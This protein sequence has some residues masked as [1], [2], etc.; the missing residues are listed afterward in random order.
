MRQVNVSDAMVRSVRHELNK[1]ETERHVKILYAC[2]SGSRAWGFPSKDSDYDVRFFYVRPISSYLKI[3][4]L[5]DV[6]DREDLHRDPSLMD[7]S[8]WDIIKTLQLASKSNPQV[9]EWLES[10]IVYYEVPE[11]TEKL[12]AIGAEFE[13]KAAMHHYASMAYTQFK[14]YLDNTGEKVLHKKYL[15]AIRP[16]MACL[17][18]DKF[19]DKYPP[20]DFSELW[21]S[22]RLQPRVAA[23]SEELE[24]LLVIK[25]SGLETDPDKRFPKID[26]FIRFMIEPC[27]SMAKSVPVGRQPD[28]MRLED[29]CISTIRHYN[30]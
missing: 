10:P 28:L 4:S 11:F 23:I 24:E 21:F 2:E 16:I 6:I 27:R 3:A 20:T 15:Y 19:P 9:W 18:L 13:T 8:G 1:I 14:N 5:R 12:R 17:W 25:R 7:F 29:L 30:L 22:L 26:A